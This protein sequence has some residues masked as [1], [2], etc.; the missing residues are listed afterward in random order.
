VPTHEHRLAAGFSSPV[1]AGDLVIV[2]LSSN[3]ETSAIND[4]SFRGGVAAFDKETGEQRWRFHT[5][6]DGYSG[7]A[8][9]STV[10]VSLEERMV[11]ASSG[12]NYTGDANEYSD[13]IIALDLETGE[14]LWSRQCETGDVFTI[15]NPQGNPDN[16]FGANP[17]LFEAEIDGELRK[18]V[19]AGAKSGIF[20]VFD[21]LTGK[22]VWSVEVG[23][24][25][26][27]AGGFL[28]N[29]AFDG[30]RLIGASNLGTSDGPGSEPSNNSSG[31][32][33]TARLV[34]L[35]PANGDVLWERQLAAFVWSPITIANGVGFVAVNKDIEAFDTATGE[36]LWSMA[37]AATIGGGP[38]VANGK[39][40]FG[41]GFT[42][43]GAITRG[44][45][46][47]AL[48]VP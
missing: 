41:S 48:A 21:R 3:E 18:L 23:G 14:K 13:A 28:N 29:G 39:L 26:A 33:T 5:A 17:I 19:G 16:D 36:K 20:W 38:A 27:G 37:S 15:R 46:L 4:A 25:S 10:S 44:T 30:E 2:G 11:F 12:N 47:H 42:Y 7:A 45:T 40:L 31:A 8:V 34:A 6:D 1:V 32:G 24:A 9:W 22:D 35:D 43:T